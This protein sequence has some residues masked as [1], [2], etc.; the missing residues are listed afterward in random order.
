MGDVRITARYVERVLA[1]V[2]SRKPEEVS[3]EDHEEVLQYIS[4]VRDDLKEALATMEALP[5]FNPPPG[6]GGKRVAA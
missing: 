6:G 2:Q 1:L 4:S 5:P 3:E